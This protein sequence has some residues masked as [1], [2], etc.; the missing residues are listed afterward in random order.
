MAAEAMDRLFYSTTEAAQVLGVSSQHVRDMIGRGEMKGT[1]LGRKI[2]VSRAEIA[3]LTGQDASEPGHETV[4]SRNEQ[5]ET[6]RELRRV[7]ADAQRL[8]AELE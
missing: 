4:S 7:L 1:R 8:L 2:L 3:R 5:A 6:I